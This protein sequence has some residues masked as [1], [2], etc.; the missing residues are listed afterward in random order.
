[1][2]LIS[3]Y[4]SKEFTRWNF[5]QA[6]IWSEPLFYGNVGFGTHFVLFEFFKDI[7]FFD[8]DFIFKFGIAVFF[9]LTQVRIITKNFK[10]SRYKQIIPARNFQDA[11]SSVHL[12]DI[13]KLISLCDAF[14]NRLRVLLASQIT[15]IEQRS[16][17]AILSIYLSL[18]LEIRIHLM[19]PC[20]KAKYFPSFN[21]PV[22]NDS[23]KK[24]GFLL[25]M[26]MVRY[27][28]AMTES[29]LLCYKCFL[30]VRIGMRECLCVCV[31]RGWVTKKE[32]LKWEFWAGKLPF[33]HLLLVWDNF[34]FPISFVTSKLFSAFLRFNTC[35]HTKSGLKKIIEKLWV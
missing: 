20:I 13:I 14:C 15:G 24:E 7:Q 3:K 4:Y 32:K 22:R 1:M 21:E 30:C 33:L 28:F 19:V 34:S 5:S 8:F 25:R 6:F 11:L 35:K 23:N 12:I 29:D 9:W 17:I 18:S 2:E 10:K 16:F 26:K 31:C 27:H